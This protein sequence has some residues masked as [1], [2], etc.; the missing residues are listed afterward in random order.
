LIFVDT[1]VLIDL[2]APGKTWRDWSL[3]QL[4]RL[5]AEDTLVVD[6]IVLAELASG[7][8][9]LGEATQWLADLGIELRSLGEK[10]AFAAGLAFRDY[11]R[12]REKRAAML[13]DFLIAGH[14][15]HLDAALLTRDATLYRRYFPDLRLITPETNP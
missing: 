10:A 4:E 6:Q 13:T 15:Q 7:F 5:G 9:A 3:A 2:V 14:A 11:R 8:P 12:T 1:N